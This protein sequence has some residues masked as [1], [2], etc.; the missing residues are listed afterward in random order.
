MERKYTSFNEIEKDL[1]A[2]KLKK[3]IDLVCLKS[4]YQSL[5]RNLS[6][7]KLFSDSIAQLKESIINKQRSLLALI[8]GFLL[9]RFFNR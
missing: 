4:D 1:R 9:R 6:I 5:L 2:L 3:D 7:S 8:G